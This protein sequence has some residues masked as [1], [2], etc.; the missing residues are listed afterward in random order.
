M[1][2]IV[3]DQRE[4]IAYECDE[5]GN[6]VEYLTHKR[7]LDAGGV[8]YKEYVHIC[9]QCHHKYNLYRIYPYWRDII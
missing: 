9:P 2:E 3:I 8:K 4:Q 6:T 7:M 5:C 1:P